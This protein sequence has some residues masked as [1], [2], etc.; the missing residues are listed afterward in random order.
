MMRFLERTPITRVFLKD[1]LE[2]FSCMSEL[3]TDM[4]KFEMRK[5]IVNIPFCE[6]CQ[7]LP[8]AVIEINLSRGRKQL[9][10]K[11]ERGGNNNV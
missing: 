5:G 2:C 9:R 6:A 3:A 4:C 11:N 7:R 1:S 10:N 8:K